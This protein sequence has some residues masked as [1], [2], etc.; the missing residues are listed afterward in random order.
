MNWELEHKKRILAISKKIDAI[1]KWAAS[2]SASIGA[3]VT[4]FNPDKPFS[5]ADYPITKNRIDGLIT[6]MNNQIQ[7]TVV[8][9]ATAEW[10]QSNFKNNELAKSLLGFKSKTGAGQ[11]DLFSPPPEAANNDHLKKYFNNNDQALKAFL[12]RKEG[13]LKLSD[14][15]WNYTSQFKSEIEMALDSGIR[16]GQPAAEMAREL[17]Q[18]LK[19]PDRVYRRFRMNLRDADGNDVLDS[20]GNKIHIKQLRR[21]YIDPATGKETWK[22]ETPPYKP[23]RGVYRSSVKNAQRLA[24]TETNM[25]YRTADHMRM[26]QFDFIVG[27]E[28][29]LSKSHV[30]YDICD[31][32]QGKYPKE[33]KYKGWHPHCMCIQTFILKTPE[34][35]KAET[36]QILN[37]EP[38][39]PQSVNQVKTTPPGFNNWIEE[40]KD[41]I[42][43]GKNAVPYFVTDNFKGGDITQGLTY[44]GIQ[45]DK[46]AQAAKDMAEQNAKV[47]AAIKQE[48][49]KANAAKAAAEAAKQAAIAAKQGAKQSAKMKAQ[50]FDESQF[51]KARKDAALWAKTKQ[52]ADDAMRPATE[53]VWKK[54]TPAEKKAGFDYTCGSG[55]FNRPL[56]GYD[57]SWNESAFKGIGKVSLDNEGGAKMIKDLTTLI[58]KSSFKTDTWLQ[59]GLEGNGADKFLG[60]NISSMNDSQLNTLIGKTVTDPAFISCGSAKGTGFGGNILNIYCPKGTKM[61]YAEP[62]SYYG[63]GSSAGWD[64]V[65]KK[66]L[67]SELETIIQRNT[68]FRIIKIQRKGKSTYIDIEV[69]AQ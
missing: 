47:Q 32:L 14:R 5:F 13:G 59:R 34:E 53:D 50:K 27:Q 45:A 57:G 28:I 4:N 3:S 12:T 54:A 58:E 62:F 16:T 66:T 43:S 42:A 19:E 24:R 40:H 2:E 48:A 39:Y 21:R 7:S 56:R 37:G 69:V 26:Q 46:A 29:S 9:G 10:E 18:F 30:V 49:E 52:G 63:G 64:G 60:V 17:R 1:Y 31:I 67:G 35:L 51:T 8:N 41:R 33:F 11:L 36:N 22:V 38:T 23:G 6:T 44:E 61:I 65:S 15:V 25:A 20:E 55:K 68:T